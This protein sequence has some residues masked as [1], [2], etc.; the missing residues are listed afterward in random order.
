MDVEDLIELV[1]SIGTFVYLIDGYDHAILGLI[2]IDGKY[3]VAYSTRMIIMSLMD[4]MDRH[5]AFEFFD[6]NIKGTNMGDGTPV[7]IED[8]L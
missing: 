4:D 2:E 8:M 6:F 3:A 5:D 7:F 1:D